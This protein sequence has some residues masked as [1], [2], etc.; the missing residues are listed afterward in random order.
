MFLEVSGCVAAPLE[1]KR[2]L[3]QGGPASVMLLLADMTVFARVLRASA[4]GVRVGIFADDRT[5]WA[6]GPRAK[7]LCNRAAQV[8]KA[9]DTAAGWLW[10][11]GKGETFGVG[12]FGADV[13]A[14][15]CDSM[16]ALVQEVKLLGVT[17]D[18]GLGRP[19]VREASADKA[20]YQLQRLR[21]ACP[22]NG[23][24]RRRARFVRQLILPKLAWGGGA[25]NSPQPK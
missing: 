16:G 20:L 21:I 9:Y 12:D 14:P 25:S 10:N 18:M 11:D 6:R 24:W 15:H 4:P 23:N 17:M 19:H 2:G 8:A 5:L 13:D 3:L 7:E 22:G 1:C